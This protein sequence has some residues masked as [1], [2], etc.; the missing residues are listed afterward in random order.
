[1]FFFL[2]KFWMGHYIDLSFGK[3]FNILQDIYNHNNYETHNELMAAGNNR[4]IAI[5]SEILWMSESTQT[6]QADLW[7]EKMFLCC[8]S[9]RAWRKDL[10]NMPKV[11][12]PHP[13]PPPN[14]HCSS[15]LKKCW[16]CIHEIWTPCATRQKT[17]NIPLTSFGGTDGREVG[18]G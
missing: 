3:L 2:P 5:S 17:A 12:F 7:C 14:P 10:T 4:I 1:M 15:L 13:P 11:L 16:V 18:V 9:L 8:F 6:L